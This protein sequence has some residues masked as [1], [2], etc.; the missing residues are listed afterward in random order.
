[1]LLCALELMRVRSMKRLG[2]KVCGRTGAYVGRCFRVTLAGDGHGKV[3]A[4]CGNTV[5]GRGTGPSRASYSRVG[6]V[7]RRS[8]FRTWNAAKSMPPSPQENTCEIL[9][10]SQGNGVVNA[11]GTK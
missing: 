11:G 2:V 10:C 9:C 7:Y 5:L 8:P 4:K 6:E 3:R 1:M